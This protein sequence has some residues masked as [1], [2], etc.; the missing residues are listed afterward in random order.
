MVYMV[1][2]YFLNRKEIIVL[3]EYKNFQDKWLRNVFNIVTVTLRA[4]S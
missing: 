2:T 1:F 4:E 3:Y